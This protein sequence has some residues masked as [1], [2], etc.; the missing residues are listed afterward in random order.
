MHDIAFN[1]TNINSYDDIPSSKYPILESARISLVSIS[2]AAKPVI[3]GIVA[4][5][6]G[7]H[8][9]WNYPRNDNVFLR[10][11]VGYQIQ[12]I[13]GI[14]EEIESQSDLPPGEVIYE[15]INNLRPNYI[16]LQTQMSARFDIP[17]SILNPSSSYTFRVRALVFSEKGS[18]TVNSQYFKYTKWGVASFKVN[19]PPLAINLL[20]NGVIA[21]TIKASE[22]PTLSFTFL[23]QDGPSCRYRIQV[24]V[25]F[26]DMFFPSMWDSGL[27]NDGPLNISKDIDVK[28]AGKQLVHG[29]TN[30]WRVYV[31]DGL[32]EGSWSTPTTFSVNTPL[33]I[34][35]F[36]FN[37]IS[38]TSDWY[39]YPLPRRLSNSGV[40]LS[41]SF[42]G[43]TRRQVGFKIK[44]FA[45]IT[46]LDGTE[47]KQTIL[48]TAVPSSATRYDLPATPIGVVVG[49]ELSLDD[50]IEY[51]QM[52]SGY[53]IS[54]AHPEVRNLKVSGILNNTSST[55][56]P[57]FSWDYW[58]PVPGDT[59]SYYQISVSEY[60]SGNTYWISPFISLPT[61]SV[62][63][64]S[65]DI[66]YPPDPIDRVAQP[67][68]HGSYRVSVYVGTGELFEG[69]FS[70]PTFAYFSVNR[71]PNPPTLLTPTSGAYSG[72]IN[73][74][75][76]PHATPDP[77]GDTI[78]YTIEYT[79]RL[80]SNS[81]W[82]FLAG[83]FQSADTSFSWDTALVPAGNDYGVRVVA[84]D[85]YA[86]SD[87]LL[88]SASALTAQGF[89]F[90]IQ[91]HAPTSPLIIFPKSESVAI[92]ALNIEWIEATPVDVDGDPVLYI[93]EITADASTENSTWQTISAVRKG[94]TNVVI[95][96]S[97]MTDGADYKVKVTARDSKGALGN[98]SY[99]PLFSISN[100]STVSDFEVLGNKVFAGTND[101]KLYSLEESFWETSED[102]DSLGSF[103]LTN[104]NGSDI[105]LQNGFLHMNCALGKSCIFR[106]R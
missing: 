57:T 46:T 22:T 20:T 100:V 75:W 32:S 77:D 38:A 85:G 60:P 101:G 84:N 14:N 79:N 43:F 97:E 70:G 68:T 82:K 36:N 17:S 74:S 8:V 104:P 28:Y 25:V 48:D 2:H 73:I 47:T 33:V 26:S 65:T 78:T 58:S 93:I 19:S 88:V 102:F 23:D 16:N 53:Y 80:A 5:I 51:S 63:Y 15:I 31:E 50:G 96:V 87:H 41:W 81:G 29:T 92:N 42:R 55:S 54:A 40:N 11:A 66:D 71:K 24:G 95:D 56:T 89:G 10:I 91:N 1:G 72:P 98:S 52:Y 61:M 13:D 106:D 34:N 69:V 83:P 30:Y 67:L 94:N 18:G 7:V 4:D 103:V 45:L 3:S 39:N 105:Y 27:I 35:G 37:T 90:T 64:G 6:N 59:Q 62:E 21:P 99:S 9:S 12:I 76:M 49:V 86:D 44:V